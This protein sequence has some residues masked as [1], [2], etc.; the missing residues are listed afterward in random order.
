MAKVRI[1]DEIAAVGS[2]LTKLADKH[3]AAIETGDVA[4]Q[5]IIELQAETSR[6]MEVRERLTASLC[7]KPPA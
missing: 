7:S 3:R 2:R 1:I 6:L 4:A 5:L